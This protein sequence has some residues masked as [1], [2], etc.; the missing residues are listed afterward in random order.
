M[1][2]AVVL[3]AILSVLTVVLDDVVSEDAAAAAAAAASVDAAASRLV[4]DTACGGHW[5]HC[6]RTESVVGLV[7]FTSMFSRFGRMTLPSGGSRI[8]FCDTIR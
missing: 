6:F 5:Q 7:G 4:N 1:I 3:L 8:C 2:P